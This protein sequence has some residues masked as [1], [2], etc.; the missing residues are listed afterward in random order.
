MYRESDAE[1]SEP[2]QAPEDE[3]TQK[4]RERWEC[5]SKE[6][7]EQV[8]FCLWISAALLPWRNERGITCVCVLCLW[9]SFQFSSLSV[10][11]TCD[12]NAI[13]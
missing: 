12:M 4:F 6:S 1:C 7:S 2:D 5:L 10:S 11:V 13:V 8:C 3:K 9:I